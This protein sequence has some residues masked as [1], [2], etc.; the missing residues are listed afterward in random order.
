MLGASRP[1]HG[2]RRL[3]G[4]RLIFLMVTAILAASPAWAQGEQA[5]SAAD[6]TSTFNLPVSVDKIK[7]ALDQAPALTFRAIEEQPT[8]R[9]QIQERRSIE[10]LVAAVLKDVKGGPVPAGGLYWNEI[11]RQVWNPV[12]HPLNQPYAAFSQSE[13]L[14]ILVENLA[15]KYLGGRALDAV[16][17]AE[18]ARAEA[19]ARDEVRQ[20]IGQYC[21]AQPRGGAGVL[22]C[23][24]SVQ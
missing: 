6:L 16:S 22:L 19:A 24:Q 3:N 21:V 9:M 11:Q 13:L 14:T 10:E 23:Q 5:S 4:M 15:G 1:E 8:F 20:S 12:D 18:R 17:T 2:A 7:A